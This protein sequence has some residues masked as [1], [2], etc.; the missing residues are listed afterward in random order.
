MSEAISCE[1]ENTAYTSPTAFSKSSG[2]SEPG[3]SKDSASAVRA[4][5]VSS[6]FGFKA[7]DESAERAKW[8]ASGFGVASSA[9]AMD[10]ISK[11]F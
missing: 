8:Y 3:G 1:A 4:S 11:S 6:V 5:V 9:F 10:R 2:S 7:R